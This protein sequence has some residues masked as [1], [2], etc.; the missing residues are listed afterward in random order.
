MENYPPP[1]GLSVFFTD[2]TDF[3]ALF[4][5]RGPRQLSAQEEKKS[6]PGFG[7]LSYLSLSRLSR[8]SR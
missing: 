3:S 1:Q 6:G 2:L 5:S 8:L 7:F 4:T